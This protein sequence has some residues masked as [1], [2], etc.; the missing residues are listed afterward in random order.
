MREVDGSRDTHLVPSD[1]SLSM[2]GVCMYLVSVGR[3]QE[4]RRYCCELASMVFECV[5]AGWICVNGSGACQGMTRGPGS[6]ILHGGVAC[7]SARIQ[8][9][10]RSGISP[11][12]LCAC[13]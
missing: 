2:L 1:A 11:S 6:Q 7:I 13:A 3:R 12:H 4:A 9:S 10:V 5:H 8:L